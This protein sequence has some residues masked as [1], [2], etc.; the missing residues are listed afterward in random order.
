MPFCS[1]CGSSIPEDVKFCPN[2]GVRVSPKEEDL[3][4]IE[5]R[6]LYLLM[7]DGGRST[8]T[9]M[10]AGSGMCFG[11]FRNYADHLVEKG[12]MKKG[13]TLKDYIITPKGK[14]EFLKK[15]EKGGMWYR[16]LEEYEGSEGYEE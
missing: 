3:T 8:F 12:L 16:F 10:M 7:S 9:R 5:I 2:C 4:N 13:E 11:M 15:A 14:H 6:I 1:K